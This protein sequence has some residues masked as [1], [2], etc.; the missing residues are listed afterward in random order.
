MISSIIFLFSFI[1][2]SFM[3]E[4]LPLIAKDYRMAARQSIFETV[5]SSFPPLQTVVET[6]L[7]LTDGLIEVDFQEAFC[8]G[9]NFTV[10]DN[11]VFIT[12]MVALEPKFCGIDTSSYIPIVHPKFGNFK[13]DMPGG[14][15]NL[16]VVIADSPLGN[17]QASLRIT[18]K[19][20]DP[21]TKMNLIGSIRR[22]V[23]SF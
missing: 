21:I 11:D 7:V 12:T 23:K 10:Y 16:T 4:A 2:S 19:P 5:L 3:T 8:N 13:Y 17:N 6:I 9:K 18:F 20:K 1:L 14:Q 22:V 15:H